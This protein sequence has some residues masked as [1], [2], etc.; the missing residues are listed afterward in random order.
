MGLEIMDFELRGRRT[1]GLR[2]YFGVIMSGLVGSRC[3]F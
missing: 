2:R 1:G 3:R